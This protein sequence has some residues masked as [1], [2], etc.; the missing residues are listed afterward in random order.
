M[1]GVHA[2]ACSGSGHPGRVDT[3]RR[4]MEWA[5]VRANLHLSLFLEIGKIS[6]QTKAERGCAKDQPQSSNDPSS[7]TAATR[8]GD[9]NSS[10]MP[11]FAVAH[12]WTTSFLYLVRI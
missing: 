1:F 4:F 8:R 5:G 7:A 10:A 11:P 9:W 3:Q 6:Q 12:G 2:L